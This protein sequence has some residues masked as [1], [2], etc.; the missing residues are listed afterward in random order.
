MRLR[1]E[2]HECTV[3]TQFKVLLTQETNTASGAL[4]RKPTLDRAGYSTAT[5]MQRITIIAVIE[6]QNTKINAD[7]K[8]ESIY[9][10]NI[11]V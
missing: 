4:Q 2:V 9:N 8:K 3:Q 7:A 1:V 10:K 5:V 6:S 11:A